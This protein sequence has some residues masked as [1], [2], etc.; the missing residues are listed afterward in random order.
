MCT[1]R[2][3][4]L[5]E[6]CN[7]LGDVALATSRPTR[8]RA[9]PLRRRRRGGLPA[10]PAPDDRSPIQ[11]REDGRVVTKPVLV[12]HY[13]GPVPKPAVAAQERQLGLSKADCGFTAAAR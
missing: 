8:R 5:K 9:A 10:R 1:G 2:R 3:R 13:L 11:G 12:A 6:T 4:A 7:D